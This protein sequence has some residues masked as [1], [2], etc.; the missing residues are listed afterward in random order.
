MPHYVLLRSSAPACNCGAQPKHTQMLWLPNK[1]FY[2]AAA[3]D[4]EEEKEERPA[5]PVYQSDAANLDWTAQ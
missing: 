1:L 3:H 5:L 4:I 2:G